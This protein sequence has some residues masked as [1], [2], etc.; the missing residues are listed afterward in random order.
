MLLRVSANNFLSFYNE[1]KFDMFPNPKKATFP[2]HVYSDYKIPVLK[3]ASIYGANGSGKSNLLKLIRFIKGFALNNTYYNEQPITLNKFRLKER[4]DDPISFSIEF[5]H[6][7][8]YFLYEARINE[9]KIETENLCQLNLETKK[10]EM[11]FKR[12][13]NRFEQD[14]LI[15]EEM[16]NAI[17][18]ILEADANVLKSF[19]SQYNTVPLLKDDRINIAYDWFESS[20]KVLSLNRLVKGLISGMQHNNELLQ[21][22]NRLIA[23]IGLGID[24][25]EIEDINLLEQEGNGELL[26]ILD[27]KL[28]QDKGITSFKNGRSL[29][30]IETRNGTPYLTRFIFKQLGIDGYVGNLEYEAQSEGTARL[31]NLIPALFDIINRECVYLIDELE[32]GIHPNLILKVMEFLGRQQTKGQLIYTTHETILLDQQKVMRPDEVWFVEKKRG[33]SVIYSLN[34]FKEHKTINIVKGYLDGRYGA[35]PFIGNLNEN[36]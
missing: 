18:N 22:T 10:Y 25:I 9:A 26:K 1:I 31:I 12:T 30:D 19:L 34:D 32:N 36:E 28:E 23:D 6:K 16:Q 7:K 3:Q 35:I 24:K 33:N 4:N 27:D 5:Y 15:S 11:I 13:G 14:K 20:L 29:F 17:T 8:I 21:F 2:N